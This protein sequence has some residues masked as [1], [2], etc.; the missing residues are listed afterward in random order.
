[1]DTA[2]RRSAHPVVRAPPVLQPCA[3]WEGVPWPCPWP[4]AG[5]TVASALAQP[6]SLPHTHPREQGACAGCAP[7]PALP[8][9]WAPLNGRGEPQSEEARCCQSEGTGSGRGVTDGCWGRVC[10]WHSAASRGGCPG[11][12]LCWVGGG[13]LSL[14]CEV[15]G[16]N[17]P[18]GSAAHVPAS[19]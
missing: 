11:C 13:G 3:P 12:G 6:F 1:M 2:C 4:R 8:A 14:F 9:G 15:L 5:S 18:L 19:P 7:G 10:A 16:A 17:F